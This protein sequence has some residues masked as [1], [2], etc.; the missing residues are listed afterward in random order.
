M[1]IR[2]R[3]LSFLVLCS[4]SAQHAAFAEPRVDAA[5]N[6]APASGQQPA[7]AWIVATGRPNVALAVTFPPERGCY[8]ADLMLTDSAGQVLPSRRITVVSDGEQFALSASPSGDVGVYEAPPPVFRALKRARTLWL[9]TPATPYVFS[10]A[11][12]AA[13][14]NSVWKACVEAVD[15]G[16][17]DEKST[18]GFAVPR[19]QIDGIAGDAM[20]ATVDGGVS[21]R[22]DRRASLRH[23]FLPIIALLL[24]IGNAFLL[25][26]VIAK[27]LSL[28]PVLPPADGHW[29]RGAALI[30][31]VGWIALPPIVYAAYGLLG[32]LL[33]MAGYLLAGLLIAAVV[34]PSIIQPA[35]GRLLD[36]LNRLRS[37]WTAV[38]PG[39]RL[40]V[41]NYRRVGRRQ[42][43]APTEKTT[44]AEILK[45]F[46]R[47][48]S[49]FKSV[50]DQRGEHLSAPRTNYIVWQFLQAHEGLND[51]AFD[52]H[53]QQELARYRTEGLP[54]AYRK[55]LRF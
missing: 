2:A 35:T 51:D 6:W 23:R 49:A 37:G 55:E 33:A 15:A 39:S 8:T 25:V 54:A 38:S 40:I 12:S 30:G 3:L 46:E 29:R 27:V 5:W 53:L 9:A 17:V 1:G 11:G 19:P 13:A 32:A 42:A 43:V 45:L 14:I 4:I 28:P 47:V 34:Q 21:D 52:A 41:E 20:D 22:S 44:D 50:A 31:A 24:A 18:E 16:E 7:K 26:K 36:R 48:G 10:L